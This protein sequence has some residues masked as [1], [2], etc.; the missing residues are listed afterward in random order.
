MA[1][2]VEMHTISL[3]NK[4]NEKMEK[5]NMSNEE[6]ASRVAALDIK[7]APNTISKIRKFED[8][9][10]AEMEN[11][12]KKSKY[13][14]KIYADYSPKAAHVA[15]IFQVLGIDEIPGINADFNLTRS[16]APEPVN[17]DCIKNAPD[18]ITD[19]KNK[20][21]CGYVDKIFDFFFLGT[22]SKKRELIQG[23]MSLSGN[24]NDCEVEIAIKNTKDNISPFDKKYVGKMVISKIQ[25]A[26]Y[27]TL[28]NADLAEICSIVFYHH[29]YSSDQNGLRARLGLATTVSAGEEK[30]PTSHR[31]LICEKGIIETDEKRE[32]VK[33]Q[34]RMNKSEIV[35]SEENFEKIAKKENYADIMGIIKKRAFPVK[36]YY[37]ISDSDV[38]SVENYDPSI[39]RFKC[40]A[41]LSLLKNESIAHRNNKIGKTADRIVYDYL[42]T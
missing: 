13:Y 4:I 5:I 19:P 7:I 18:F 37:V 33:S 29:R 32:F 30:R 41:T 22:V 23:A 36:P 16:E 42:F 24:G 38:L 34:L 21:F 17:A 14:K 1:T 35:I 27:C 39:D 31:V 25:H 12:A 28:V 2:A 15:A 3:S 10:N 40:I 8:K 6:L 11:L 26:C 20:A 9:L